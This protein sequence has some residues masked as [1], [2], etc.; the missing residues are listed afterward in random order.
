MVRWAPRL[1][2]PQ[3]FYFIPRWLG[4]KIKVRVIMLSVA[5]SNY[6]L[7][8]LLIVVFN[9]IIN[10]ISNRCIHVYFSYR[11]SRLSGKV[12][13]ENRYGSPPC[14]V[15][16]NG[17]IWWNHYVYRCRSF[18]SAVTVLPIIFL[19]FQF[20]RSFSILFCWKYIL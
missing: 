15:F 20:I 12:D 9:T 3:R 16:A 1:L 2:E 10:K 11:S 8:H 4:V 18:I 5:H 14:L 13:N 6:L 19:F 17:F 7:L